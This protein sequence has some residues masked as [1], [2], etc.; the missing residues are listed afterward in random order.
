VALKSIALRGL[1]TALS[2]PRLF[3]VA[4]IDRQNAFGIASEM[5]ATTVNGMASLIP[6]ELMEPR[7]FGVGSVRIR[8]AWNDRGLTT[9]AKARKITERRRATQLTLRGV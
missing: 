5:A 9:I 3:N 4:H 1:E 6:P 7:L 8:C 2:N